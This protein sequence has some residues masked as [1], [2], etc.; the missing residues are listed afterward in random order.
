MKDQVLLNPMSYT[1]CSTLHHLSHFYV[2]MNDFEIWGILFW[3]ATNV[4]L[5]GRFKFQ[6]LLTN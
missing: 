1:I 5:F 4:I 6:L 2:K 3:L